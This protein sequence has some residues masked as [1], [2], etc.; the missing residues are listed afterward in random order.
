VI[1]SAI[2]VDNDVTV[3]ITEVTSKTDVK[4]FNQKEN[5]MVTKKTSKSK[6]PTNKRTQKK[7]VGWKIGKLYFI[8][9]VTMYLVGELI[10]FDDH[11]L[12]LRD[13]AWVADTGRFAEAMRTGSLRE[14]EPYPDGEVLVGRGAIV[15][16]APW[17]HGPLRMVVE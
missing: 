14:V 8:R 6:R 2:D 13:A 15:D 5:K 9:T 17:P 10:A 4:T 3:T 11:E 1:A 12:I 7:A 16:A